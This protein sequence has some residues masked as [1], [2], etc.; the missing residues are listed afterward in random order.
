MDRSL[1]ALTDEQKAR[2]LACESTEELL[3]FA[4]SE[5]F[6]LTDEQLESVAGG[7][8]NWFCSKDEPGSC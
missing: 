8:K 1:G 4:K 7:M 5:G 3:E 2:V 6:E